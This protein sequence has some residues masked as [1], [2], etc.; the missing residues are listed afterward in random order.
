MG[1]VANITATKFPKQGTFLGKRVRVCF[2]YDTSSEVMGTVDRDDA[3]A[4]W[5]MVIRLDTGRVVLSTECMYSPVSEQ[6]AKS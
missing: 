4:P 6:Q 2:H 3:E 5:V 1:A